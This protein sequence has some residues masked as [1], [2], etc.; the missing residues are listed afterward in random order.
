[1]RVPKPLPEPSVPHVYV[2]KGLGAGVRVGPPPKPASA[3]EL[4]QSGDGPWRITLLPRTEE[5]EM[6]TR[7]APSSFHVG[8]IVRILLERD[9]DDTTCCILVQ[10]LTQ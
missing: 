9:W 5:R 10:K 1:M 4:G 7:R 3:P 2:K 8:N 6:I